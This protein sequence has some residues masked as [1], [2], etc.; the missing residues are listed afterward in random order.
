[1]RW[2]CNFFVRNELSSLGCSRLCGMKA[3]TSLWGDRGGVVDVAQS[4]LMTHLVIKGL[5]PRIGCAHESRVPRSPCGD[6]H[7]EMTNMESDVAHSK[8]NRTDY[9]DDIPRKQSQLN[10]RAR[11]KLSILTITFLEDFQSSAAHGR[12]E[13]RK[14]GRNALTGHRTLLDDH[15]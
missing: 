8:L 3:E 11:S 7:E 12:L 1:M 4:F 6:E 2:R 5:M 13:R 10:L 15:L 9:I 14:I